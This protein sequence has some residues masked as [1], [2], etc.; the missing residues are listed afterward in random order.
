MA[1]SAMARSMGNHTAKIGVRMVPSPKP[2]KKVRMET[3]NALIEMIKRLMNSFVRLFSGSG[4]ARS[5]RVTRRR[6]DSFLSPSRA[7]CW[8]VVHPNIGVGS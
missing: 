1:V 5:L 4:R 7:F 6:S 2:E 3:R 8:A